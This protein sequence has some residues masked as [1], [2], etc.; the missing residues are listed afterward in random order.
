MGLPSRSSDSCICLS[1]TAA[2]PQSPEAVLGPGEAA[3][4]CW[5]LAPPS[6]NPNSGLPSSPSMYLWSRPGFPAL[7]QSLIPSGLRVWG[8]DGVLALGGAQCIES[9]SVGSIG[10]G[11]DI[12]Y[13]DQD[14]AHV[15]SGLGL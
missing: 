2:A 14:R 6:R 3:G 12:L 8:A 4:E 9:L 1:F 7:G 11:Y 5:A 13:E 15:G 10:C